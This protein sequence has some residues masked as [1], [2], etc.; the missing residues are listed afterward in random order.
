MEWIQKEKAFKAEGA[1]LREFPFFY[2]A[3]T[4]YPMPGTSLGVRAFWILEHDFSE[5]GQRPSASESPG[6]LIKM[7]IPG[8]TDTV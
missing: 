5:C 7:Q 4:K 3:I 8:V 2:S 6:H 1:A